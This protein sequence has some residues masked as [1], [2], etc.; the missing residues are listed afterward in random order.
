MAFKLAAT[1]ALKEAV[2]QDTAGLLE[3]VM[4]IRVF[5]PDDHAGDV[6]SDLNKKRA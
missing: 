4:T 1:Q 2:G 6:V 3:T 5:A